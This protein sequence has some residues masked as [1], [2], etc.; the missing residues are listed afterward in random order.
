[1]G[2]KVY[3]WLGVVAGLIVSSLGFRACVSQVSQDLVRH[4]IASSKLWLGSRGL[5]FRVSP[6]PKVEFLWFLL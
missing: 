4:G 5:G 2:R 3:G 1:M 6:R